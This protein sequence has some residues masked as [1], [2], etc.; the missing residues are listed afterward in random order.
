[1]KVGIITIHN[2]PN[3]GAC[4]QSYALYRYIVN[5]GI[6]CELIDLKRPVHV[7][8]VE[9][10]DFKPY[11]TPKTSIIVKIKSIVKRIIK[12]QTISKESTNSKRIKNFD[13]FNKSIKLSTPYYSIDSLYS[14]PPQYDIYIS[15]S[16]QLWNPEQPFPIEPYFLTFVRNSSAK[17]ISYASSIGISSLDSSQIKDFSRWLSSYDA[18]SVREPDAAKILQ[19]HLKQKIEIVADPTFLLDKEDWKNV[20]GYQQ[21]ERKDRIKYLLVYSVEEENNGKIFETAHA[22]ARLRGLKIYAVI[23][24]Y[25]LSLRKFACD[26]VYSCASPAC[27]LRLMLDADFVVASS[28]HGTAFSLNFNKDFVSILPD[29]FSV[30]QRSLE[31]L[32]PSISERIRGLESFDVKTLQP[33]DYADINLRLAHLRAASQVR[34]KEI[35]CND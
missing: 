33:L 21:D 24:R 14:N 17:K 35:L 3:Y 31:V 22:I 32:F 9:S 7:G 2:S 11:Y 23:G 5:Q 26:R 18:I 25:S 16:D 6:D 29:R 20:I 1:M 19:P 30:R 15:G 13:E 8:Y 27:F 12:P 34:L 28:F 10:P 4:L